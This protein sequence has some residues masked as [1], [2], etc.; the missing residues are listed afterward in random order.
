MQYI[1]W[2]KPESKCYLLYD[3]IYIAFWKRKNDRDKKQAGD[4]EGLGVGIGINIKEQM[5]ISGG[6]ESVIFGVIVV[7]QLHASI[8]TH[9]NVH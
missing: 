1:K 9:R 8:K 3:F 6:D 5:T 2:K 7:T 4:C